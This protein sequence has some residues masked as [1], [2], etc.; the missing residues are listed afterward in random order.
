MGGR[1]VKARVPLSRPLGI[2]LSLAV[3]NLDGREGHGSASTGHGANPRAT[4]GHQRGSGPTWER[5]PRRG[6]RIAEM[7]GVAPAGSG[8]RCMMISAL[9]LECPR[10]A[11]KGLG[12]GALGTHGPHLGL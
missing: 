3:V 5:G 1:G 7:R 9:A 6:H 2:T 8:R 12:G 10:M 4:R 11:L